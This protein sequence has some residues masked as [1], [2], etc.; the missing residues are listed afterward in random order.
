MGNMATLEVVMEILTSPI[1]KIKMEANAF[2]QRSFD[3]LLLRPC[4]QNPIKGTAR[5][6]LPC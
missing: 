6:S 5:V 2:A 4:R 1:I 3:L